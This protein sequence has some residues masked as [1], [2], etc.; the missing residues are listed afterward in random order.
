MTRSDLIIKVARHEPDVL[1]AAMHKKIEAA[2][3][4]LFELERYGEAHADAIGKMTLELGELL[5]KALETK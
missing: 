4:I 5:R 3:Q 2:Y 1:V